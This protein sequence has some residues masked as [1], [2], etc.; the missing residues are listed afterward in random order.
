[1]HLPNSTVKKFCPEED[2]WYATVHTPFAWHY[3]C[4]RAASRLPL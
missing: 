1:M 3:H 2:G 4:D